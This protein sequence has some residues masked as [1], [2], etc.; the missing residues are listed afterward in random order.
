MDIVL[1]RLVPTFG[2]FKGLLIFFLNAEGIVSYKLMWHTHKGGDAD[3]LNSL[4]LLR[5]P[6]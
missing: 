2:Y 6:L 5:A 1:E 4:E 3:R